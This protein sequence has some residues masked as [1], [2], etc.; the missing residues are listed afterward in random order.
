MLKFATPMWRVLPS[1]F[2]F[3]SAP[4]VSARGVLDRRPVHEQQIDVVGLQALRLSSTDLAKSAAR[5][6]SCETFVARKMSCAERRT[7]MPSPTPFSVP[8]FHAV[9]MWR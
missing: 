3:A 5:R 4:I 6:Y 2:A 7:L 9:S 1:R 8:Y